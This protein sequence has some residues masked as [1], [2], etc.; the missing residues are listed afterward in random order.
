MIKINYILFLI[1]ISFTL[2]FD[3][4]IQ[5]AQ[6]CQ[7]A[8]STSPTPSGSI[9]N[10][11]KYETGDDE[12]CEKCVDGYAVSYEGNKCIP[13]S[14]C[15]YLDEGNKKCDECYQGYY[16]NGKECTKISI[17]NCLISNDDGDKCTYCALYS[18]INEDG[19]R[20]QLIEK[21]VEGC[22]YYDNNGNCNAC[23]SHYTGSGS[24]SSFTCTFNDCSGDRAVEYCKYC[25][26]GYYTDTSDGNCKPYKI[27]NSNNSKTNKIGCAFLILMLSLLI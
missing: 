13:F 25:Q 27:A 2:Q 12:I 14:Y 17:D 22:S 10:C 3:H 26:I 23:E 7:K 1:L 6:I 11:I 5:T 18:K 9:A 24:G 16:F 15:N 8:I 21:I 4:C 20:C 19:S